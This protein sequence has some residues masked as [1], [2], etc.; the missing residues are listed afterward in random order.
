MILA[1][2]TRVDALLF[3]VGGFVCLL[4]LAAFVI[5]AS[6]CFLQLGAIVSRRRKERLNAAFDPIRKI[7]R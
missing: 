5:I 2:I 3:G 1:T 7:R 4:A 6:A